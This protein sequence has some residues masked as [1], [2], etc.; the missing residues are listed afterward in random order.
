[1]IK[2][3][4]PILSFTDFDEKN[5]YLEL[6]V[7][8]LERGYG[9]TLGNSLRRIMLSSLPG[10][11]VKWI[12]CNDLLHELNTIEGVK[13]DLVEIVLNIKDIVAVINS[14]EEQKILRIEKNRAGVITAGDIIADPDV[15]IINPD[16]HIATLSENKEFF[17]E[18]A[19]VK[20][21]GYI[22]AEDNK[23]DLDETLGKIAID[24]LFTPVVKS[25][26]R[27]EPTR[28]G[29]SIDY[30]KLVQQVWTNGSIKPEDAVSLAAKILNDL[31]QIYIGL[32]N[33]VDKM[34]FIKK[35]EEDEVNPVIS[36]TIEELDMK[37]RSKHGIKRAG[38]NTVEELIN[39]TE[40]EVLKFQNIGKKSLE[41]IKESL[42]KHGLEF[43]KEDD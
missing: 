14:D 4:K 35:T 11:A 19:L 36:L 2:F 31:L 15:E 39:K 26:F 12:K 8:P 25:N 33:K 13:E 40:Q 22:S 9:V 1:M 29:E 30:D 7:E 16:L 10:C 20:G 18:M 28:V 23:K 24:S 41:N 43:R 5:N 38:I 37:P 17:L 3:E 34:E 32:N 6:T 21:R 27:V 42:K